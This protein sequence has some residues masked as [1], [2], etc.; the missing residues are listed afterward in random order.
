M[1][2][3]K[4]VPSAL[5]R[6][7]RALAHDVDLLTF[8]EPTAYVYNPL[9]YARAPS[10]RYLARYGAPKKEALFVGM[11]PGP[12]GM[13]QTGVPFGDIAMV[14]DFL[15]IEGRTER[16]AKEHPK[17]AIE[18]FACKRSEVSGTRLWGFVKTRF[19]TPERF[20]AR[21]FVWN[22][23]PLVFMETS[24]A[25][26]TPD[27]LPKHELAPLLARCDRALVE[28]ADALGVELVIGVGA[29]ATARATEA[30]AGRDM[31]IGTV[32]HPSP[33]SPRANRGWADEAAKDLATLGVVL[34]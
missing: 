12:F 34:P 4:P 30:F 11:N 10:E 15:G 25:N 13:A 2:K 14:R 9:V 24:G 31:R 17:R 22:Y 32:L 33:A 3:T 26:R 20:F 8:G 16:P 23:C 29:W 18:G 27:K 5:V 19:V 7:S 1:N 6:T 28:V 21:F